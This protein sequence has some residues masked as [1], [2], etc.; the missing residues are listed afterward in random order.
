MKLQLKRRILAVLGLMVFLGA[1]TVY[2]SPGPLLLRLSDGT[3]IVNV[4]DEG[5]NDQDT[6]AGGDPAGLGQVDWYTTNIPLGAWTVGDA[7][8][9]GYP[10]NTPGTLN[11]S[12][13]VS[14]GSAGT[15]NIWMTQT[16]LTG[17]A[18][19]Q[20]DF[21]TTLTSGSGVSVS[22]A[23]YVDY[24]NTAFAMSNL[25]ASSGTSSTTSHGGSNGTVTAS[26]PYSITLMTTLTATKSAVSFGGY[27]DY[28][29]APVQ[30]QS[31]PEPASVLLLG[32]GL[33]GLAWKVR[34]SG[35]LRC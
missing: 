30:S 7:N 28:V 33:A 35:R 3:H 24:S 21:G 26:N 17:S 27:T 4:V 6:V 2:A 25:L 8:G 16:N 5:T 1:S 15:L 23:A 19:F 12:F 10:F 31:V 22:Y 32:T 34:K 9:A 13:T 11:L 20:F 18:Q 14:P 29:D